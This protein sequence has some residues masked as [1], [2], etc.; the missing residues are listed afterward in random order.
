MTSQVECPTLQPSGRRT[1]SDV[2]SRPR[3]VAS[4]V[5]AALSCLAIQAG[6]GLVGCTTYQPIDTNRELEERVRQQLGAD[7]DIQIP[8]EIDDR[9][10][11]LALLRVNPSGSEH[12][13]TTAI[14]DF[15]FA[16]LDL[17]YELVPTRNAIETFEAR[18]G[19][20]LSFVNLFVGIARSVHLNPFYVEVRDLQK[21]SFRDGVV[22]SQGHIVAGMYVDGELRTY[23]FLPYEP[24]SYRDF[25]PIDDVTA[26]AHYYNNL[27]AEALLAG[28][29][30]TAGKNLD[31]AVELAPEFAKAINNYGVYLL[32]RQ[33]ID[34]AI[35]LYERSLEVDPTNVAMLSNLARAYQT[36]GDAV[37]ADALLGQIEDSN[38]RNPYFFV[39][40]GEL[41]LAQGDTARALEYMAQALRRDSN[42]PE[43]HVG[44][45][46]VYIALGD[47]KKARHHIE[48]ALKLDATHT[49]A[50][51]YAVMLEMGPGSLPEP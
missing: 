40:R 22:L 4:S 2:L 39:Y 45:A 5:V 41:A 29:L 10:R 20:C 1:G 11:E 12:R 42:L 31:I 35:A 24:K 36:A 51:T 25:D 34:E 30:D 18:S 46:K 48:R 16:D 3:R 38:Q 27:G 6:V 32:R 13:R 21:W 26:M 8:F 44:L 28:D 19:N 37:R 23:D 14:L 7:R 50:R 9:I 15:V 49:D 17:Q 47:L 33:R 43:V